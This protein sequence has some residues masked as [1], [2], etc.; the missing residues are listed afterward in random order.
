V[1]DA[2]TGVELRAENFD[3]FVNE[4]RRAL[5]KASAEI[6][7]SFDKGLK[8]V[9]TTVDKTGRAIAS[10]LGKAGTEGAK[11][12]FEPIEKGAKTAT[13]KVE[14]AFKEQTS[15]VNSSL[16][17]LDSGKIKETGD[18]LKHLIAI[19]T[20]FFIFTQVADKL[21]DVIAEG[22][23]AAA[24]GRVQEQLVKTT[25]QSANLTA[26]QLDHMASSLSA[27]TGIDDELIK[28]SQNVLL[29]FRQV[30]DET[31][32]GNDVFTRATKDAADLSTVLG[33]DMKGSTLQLGKALADPI[34]GI[35]ALRRS[36]VNFTAQQQDQIKTLVASGKTLEAQKLILTEVEH[37]VGGAAAAAADPMKRLSAV[38][39]ELKES[40]GG[41]LL[42]ALGPLADKFTSL[43]DG[44][45]PVLEEL[46]GSLGTALSAAI[47][48]V[49]TVA[50]SLVPT[51]QPL[52][53]FASSLIG[54]IAGPL[55]AGLAALGPV[56]KALAPPIGVL[57]NVFGSALTT[58]IRAIAP[59]VAT[60][61]QTLAPI[62]G[63]IA[64][65]FG[66]LLDQAGPSFI[67][68][69]KV[70]GD[71][72]KVIGPA[73]NDALGKALPPL[74]DALAALAPVLA[75][76]AAI[77][78]QD[79]ANAVVA[80][81]PVLPA[82]ATALGAVAS[83]IGKIPAP[84]LA[85]LIEAWIVLKTGQAAQR[86]LR[87]VS[88]GV[89]AFT[90]ALRGAK[91]EEGLAARLL[92]AQGAEAETLGTKGFAAGKKLA[93]LRDALLSVGSKAVGG[94]K[95]AGSAVAGIGQSAAKSAS[96]AISSIGESLA[97]L[98]A[99]VGVPLL[100]A[101]AIA[102]LGVA[103]FL[104]Y[105]KFKPFHDAVDATGRFLRD[106]LLP[107]LIDT[108]K[109]VAGFFVAAWQT[110]VRVFGPVV[111]AMAGFYRAIGSFILEPIRTVVKIVTDLIHGDWQAA[112]LDMVSFPFRMLQRLAGIFMSIPRL[113]GA[114]FNLVVGLVTTVW[115]NIGRLLLTLVQLAWRGV[116]AYWTTVPGLLLKAL[117]ALPALMFGI[118][119]T[120]W[121]FVLRAVVA[122]IGF[123]MDQIILL[124]QRILNAVFTLGPM[125][126]SFMIGL[127]LRI[128]QITIAG[129]GALLSFIGSLPSRALGAVRAIVP[130]IVSL[131][132]A[133]WAR[134]GGQ[135]SSGVGTVVGF[136][137]GLPGR[138]FRAL[139]S[140]P[141]L[142]SGA[143]RGAM[144]AAWNAAKAGVAL[145][146][147]AITSIPGKITA[148]IPKIASAA[149]RIG[150]AILSNI[151]RGLSAAAGFVGDLGS[152]LWGAVKDFINARLDTI[153]NFGVSVFG[154]KISPF[155]SLPHLAR[156]GFINDPTVALIGEAGRELVLPLSDRRRSMQLLQQAGLEGAAS[157]SV[158]VAE[159]AIQLTVIVQGAVDPRTARGIG[160][161]VGAG[162]RTALAKQ[163][164]DLFART[165]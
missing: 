4:V 79:F 14:A 145:V 9:Q 21:K 28:S 89:N 85:K 6:Q 90:G 65:A 61:A 127:W 153:R 73:L 33:T 108:G 94:L 46:G 20:G 97:P 35:T 162:V 136:V 96:G 59:I 125:F 37:Q 111:A 87:L 27:Q 141:G 124:P 36:G 129:I 130:L 56:V 143:I 106:K 151:G 22:R 19:G 113:L 55:A 150:S 118:F 120:V 58:A 64:S 122:G 123:V 135:F 24:L 68:V 105:K 101:A 163:E 100:I 117:E 30:R 40:L 152:K 114:A 66:S 116:V 155:S 49:A 12:G 39:K 17:K 47:T 138:A 140:L 1:S 57:A 159:G 147:G 132:Q 44:L 50:R 109:A 34:K 91:L 43:A 121:G 41:G 139:A 7:R 86:N 148:A 10:S 2:W 26:G 92:K 84:I 110:A 53:I 80:V 107:A 99:T 158:T 154:H 88:D 131:F 42:K 74:A 81:A 11:K 69:G 142:L 119:T 25:G 160:E 63:R 71:T 3:G 5:D 128:A 72:L 98:I 8:P 134:W 75:Q 112:I 67:K 54:A 62:I 77:L 164:I 38:T 144:T 15:K 52:A 126:Y 83:A 104:A 48:S 18:G 76:V 95:T 51:L 102:A 161:D 13:E 16:S 60:L 23:E 157:T 82:I 45:G 78:A 165:K 93:S 137:A 146:V 31:G 29:T 149:G 103:V 133:A 115:Q 70:I 32:K 156:G